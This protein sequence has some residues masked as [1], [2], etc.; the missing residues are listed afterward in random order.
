LPPGI[1][2]T[3]K[4]RAHER[5]PKKKEKKENPLPGGQQDSKCTETVA[6]PLS[7][8]LYLVVNQR[9]SKTAEAEKSPDPPYAHDR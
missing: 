1:A 8:A 7:S 3:T 6:E 9:A 4:T 2:G 5:L